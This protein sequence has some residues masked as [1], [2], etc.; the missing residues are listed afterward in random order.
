MGDQGSG[1]RPRVYPSE[2][3]ELATSLY[4]GGATVR[5][6]QVALPQGYKAQ[7]I[8]ERHLPERRSTAKRDQRGENNHM[9]KGEAANYQALHLRVQQSRGRPSICAACETT[10]GKF[11]W[12][13]MT[14]NYADV[15]DYIRLC[16]SCHRR[17]DAD[18]RKKTGRSTREGVVPNV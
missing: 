8:L 2:I 3:V 4:M 7:R 12:A 5:E 10:D 6:V 14:G 18:R 9:W 1:A 16:I 17:F 15:Y 13:N 11:E